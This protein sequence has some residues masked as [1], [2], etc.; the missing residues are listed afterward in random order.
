[1]PPKPVLPPKPNTTKPPPKR[2]SFSSSL[3]PQTPR[4]NFRQL[5]NFDAMN[6]NA[7]LQIS[8]TPYID[9]TDCSRNR[10]KR[11]IQIRPPKVFDNCTD[12]KEYQPNGESL[13][14]LQME[15]EALNKTILG[16]D[17][18]IES[19]VRNVDNKMNGKNVNKMNVNM[20]G[21]TINFMDDYMQQYSY[22]QSNNNNINSNNNNNNNS[23]NNNNGNL[24]DFGDEDNTQMKTLS[25]DQTNDKKNNLNLIDLLSVSSQENNSSVNNSSNTS[26]NLNN[27]NTSYFNFEETSF[28]QTQQNNFN[29]NAFVTKPIQVNPRSSYSNTQNQ[30]RQNQQ[31]YQPRNTINID[32]FSNQSNSQNQMMFDFTTSSNQSNN[33]NNNNLNNNNN[34]NYNY[35]N[36][37]QGNKMNLNYS[38]MPTFI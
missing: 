36:T 9:Q 26:N 16:D 4:T 23:N 35:M 2:P 27:S 29:S 31:N 24:F 7:S 33:N 17:I 5:N 3:N 37:T 8:P 22:L 32:S 13:R 11:Y 19:Y 6:L 25:N 18:V 38:S 10:T 28:P 12:E 21:N 1:M 15:K 34:N 30:I 14:K 20:N